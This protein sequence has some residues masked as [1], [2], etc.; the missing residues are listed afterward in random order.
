[1]TGLTA[2]LPCYNEGEQVD[3]AYET[4][5]HALA[6]L[7]ELELLIID[8]GS[9]DDTLTRIKS[10]AATDPRV[11]YLSF[12]R[13]FGLEAAQ[14]A[15]F[16]YARQPWSVQLDA[17]LQSPPGEV[18]PLLAKAAEGYDVVFGVREHRQDP[19]LRR[20]GSAGT[21]WIGHRVLGIELPA[22]AS[23]FRVV[24]T[25]V[26]RTLVDQRAGT[27]YF[28]AQLTQAGARCAC[29]Q[30]RHE[31]RAGRSKWRPAR[32]AGHSFELF[33]G[34]SWRPLNA[35]FA[36]AALGVAAALAGLAMVVAGA[37]AAATGAVLAVCA[38]VLVST[39]VTA[40]YLQRMLLE[41]R[42]GRPYYI[43]E[44]NVP[45]RPEDTLDGA[46]PPVAPPSAGLVVVPGNEPSVRW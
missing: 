44:A 6:R 45:L 12:T 34:Y 3:R 43:R 2:V 21:H 33:F 32:L 19:W 26:A 25:A 30:T 9:T 31:R 5:I 38:L 28:I 39:A 37:T 42:P 14:S 10:L 16:R 20:L 1:M 29:V 11:H 36:L 41:V 4:V 27:P 40:R 22:G 18:W 7:G 35:V 17:D 13:N 15:G 23:T 24:R 46:V 8:D